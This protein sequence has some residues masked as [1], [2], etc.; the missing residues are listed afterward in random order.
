LQY[1]EFDAL[2]LHG[3]SSGTDVAIRAFAL[4]LILAN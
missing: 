1:L 2:V 3:P 4:R